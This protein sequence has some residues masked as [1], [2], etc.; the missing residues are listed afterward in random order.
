MHCLNYSYCL[1]NAGSQIELK[2]GSTEIPLLSLVDIRATWLLL[3]PISQRGKHMWASKDTPAWLKQLGLTCSPSWSLRKGTSREQGRAQW[4]RNRQRRWTRN[5]GDRKPNRLS[6]AE[7]KVSGQWALSRQP[8]APSSTEQNLRW[9]PPCSSQL[10]QSLLSA[11]PMFLTW[12]S[13]TPG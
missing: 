1:Y 8:G 5:V 10:P 13:S 12:V 2:L 4:S 11:L 6:K 3:S 7:V 9:G